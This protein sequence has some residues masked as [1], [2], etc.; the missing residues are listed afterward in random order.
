MPF[1]G[2]YAHYKPLK[3]I[4]EN[5]QV[6]TLL[7]R[8]RRVEPHSI[9]STPLNNVLLSDLQVRESEIDFVLAIDG[10]MAEVPVDNGYPCAA[11][12][13]VT[14]ASVLLDVAKM[15]TLD[16]KRPI[17]PK[18]FRTLEDAESI[19]GALPGSNVVIDDEL[20]ACHSFRRALFEVFRSKQVSE[21]G[22]SILNTY[23]ALL[24]LKPAS[25]NPQSCPYNDCLRKDKSYSAGLA[26]YQCDC[27]N[28]RALFSTDALR[29][30]EF[31]NPEG[32]NQSMLTETMSVLERVWV[33]HFLR[34]LER[35]NLLPV[36]QR[37]AIVVDGPLAVFGAPAWL[38]SAIKIELARINNAAKQAIGDKNF[39]L[40]MFGVEKTGAFMEHLTNIDKGPK[41]EGNA[42]PHQ[43][44]CLLTDDYIKQ[45]IRFSNSEG[46]Y[47]RNTYFG[48][49]A[50]YKTASGALI[51]IN[52]PFLT[53]DHSDLK[54]AE[55]SQFPRLADTMKLL[56]TLVSA[57]Y[58]NSVTPLISAHAEAAIPLN[59][60][61]RVLEKL[62]Q[63]LMSQNSMRKP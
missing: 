15:K 62:A 58:R 54:R 56:D 14:V 49:K 4:S 18:E 55:V 50:F 6:Q 5:E 60:G 61:R 53:E 42:L 43:S 45:R 63:Q 27:S 59:L 26:E 38:S 32:S 39:E 24:R 28:V 44:A 16:A 37:L 25:L 21:S 20:D 9:P 35:E 33:I 52:S 41:G 22:E 11:V 48:R 29:I 7:N 34:T 36:L 12:G 40:L 23:E 46:M 1:E 47:G 17:D 3:R 10:S 30:H 31:M 2:E 51:V 57:R 8:A 13:Y 19:D